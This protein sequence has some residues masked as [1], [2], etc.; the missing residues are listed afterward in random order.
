MYYSLELELKHSLY[1]LS[2]NLCK[3]GLIKSEYQRYFSGSKV[4]RH[5][6]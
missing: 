3:D 5:M 4:R 1:L 2:P 6:F